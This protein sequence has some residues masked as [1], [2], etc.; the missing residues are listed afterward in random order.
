M[1]DPP[2][3][4]LWGVPQLTDGGI[5]LYYNKKLLSDAGITPE[6]LTGLVWAPGGGSADTLLPILQKLTV[7]TA[8]KR[9]D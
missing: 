7:D 4:L 6:Q 1:A 5:A 9:G 8:G 2:R 3:L